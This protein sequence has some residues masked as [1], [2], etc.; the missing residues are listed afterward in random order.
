MKRF[1]LIL[2]ALT[3]SVSLFAQYSSHRYYHLQDPYTAQFGCMPFDNEIGC[4]VYGSRY[5]TAM[6]KCTLGFTTMV[7]VPAVGLL[8]TCIGLGENHSDRF[9]DREP[10]GT[11]TALIISGAVIA[12]T[13]LAL[14]IPLYKSGKRE[15]N[16]MMDDY[17]R[18]YC[19]QHRNVS[20]K[21]GATRNG[22]GLALSF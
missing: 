9:M 8:V 6:S 14:G 2:V 16:A 12:A 1:L 21:A 3:M 22:I 17:Y 7:G 19:P 13:G 11:G 20:L 10:D 4:M 5:R 18:N 15:V